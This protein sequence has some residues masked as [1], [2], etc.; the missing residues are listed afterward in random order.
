MGDP[1][2]EVI[3]AALA[4]LVATAAADPTSDAWTTG[5]Y[6]KAGVPD[7]GHAW[8]SAELGSA[9]AVVTK[10]SA[11]RLPRFH[12]AQ[13]GDVFARLVAP[14]L[15]DPSGDVR[16]RFVALFDS[17]EAHHALMKLYMPA[18]A[19]DAPSRELIETFGALFD[20]YTRMDPLLQPFLASFGASDP[21]HA[22]RVAGMMKIWAGL[23][24]AIIGAIMIA[25]QKRVAIAYR[26]AM[27][28]YVA[29]VTPIAFVHLDADHQQRIR[30]YVTKLGA[31]TTGPLRDA[32][33]RV[34]HTLPP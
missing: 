14:T 32:A 3:V 23:G 21:K 24:D 16:I 30:D 12:G 27:L 34:L 22:N 6:V 29:R 33:A 31:A 11:E 20:D 2:R 5:D 13:S 19:L 7:P 18:H 15:A 1:R 28:D 4:L 8:T 17:E 9:V 26:V 10:V 25:D